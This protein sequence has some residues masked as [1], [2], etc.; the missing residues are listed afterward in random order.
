MQQ[1]KFRH[2]TDVRQQA[3][4]A[5]ARPARPLRWPLA[6]RQPVIHSA[7]QNGCAW[8]IDSR[9]QFRNGGRN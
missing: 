4:G 6:V 1:V 9:P 7:R 8:P 2:E 3:I 5:F